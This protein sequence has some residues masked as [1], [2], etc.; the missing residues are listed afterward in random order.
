MK[1]GNAA[2]QKRLLLV[3]GVFAGFVVVPA[4]RFQDGSGGYFTGA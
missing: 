2:H 3:R 1:P 4:R